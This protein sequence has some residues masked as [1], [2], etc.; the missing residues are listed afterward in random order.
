MG[1]G[2]TN[3][4]R[5]RRLVKCRR[6][7][8]DAEDGSVGEAG[9]EAREASA[10]EGTMDTGAVGAGRRDVDAMGKVCAGFGTTA[11][12]IATRDAGRRDAEM[13]TTSTTR[14]IWTTTTTMIGF[15]KV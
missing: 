2:G 12:A 9:E 8:E 7:D 14:T 10:E 15:Y 11:A 13:N 3:D 1:G 6:D 5:R 4:R